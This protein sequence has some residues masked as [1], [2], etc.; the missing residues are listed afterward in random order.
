MSATSRLAAFVRIDGPVYEVDFAIRRF[1]RWSPDTMNGSIFATLRAVLGCGL[2]LT[3][4]GL[5][6]FASAAETE[7]KAGPP[8]AA[9]T[10]MPAPAQVTNFLGQ[11]C[12][13]CHGET[14]P[15]AGL[16]LTAFRDELSFLKARKKWDQ[17]IDLVH[18]GT[19]P[20]EDAPQPPLAEKEAFLKAVRTLFENADKNAKPDPGRVTV[21]RLNRAEYNNTIRDLLLVDLKP[22]EDFPS[23][24]VGHG[25][26]NIGDVLTLSPVLMERYLAAA[27]SIAERAVLVKLPPVPRRYLAARFL[28]PFPHN[29][30]EAEARFRPFRPADPNPI[31]AGP[32]TAGADYLKFTADADLML[33]ARLYAAKDA[34]LPVKVALFISGPNLADPSP[35]AEVDQLMGGNLKACKPMRILKVFEITSHDPQKIQEIEFPISKRGDIQKAGLAVVRP[36]EGEPAPTLFVENIW[37]EGPLEVRPL[38]HR[39][40]L[41]CDAAKPRAEQ[42]R[43]VIGR[44]VSRAFRRPATAAEVERYARIVDQAVA[45]GEPWEAGIQLAIQSVL[46]S[47]KF[48]FRFELDD[49]PEAPETRPIDEYQLAARL[50]YFLWSSLPDAEL[51]ELAA[52]GQL[53]ANLGSQVRRMLKDKKAN[54]LVENFALQW[55]QLG[56]LQAHAPDARLFPSFNEPLRAAMAEETRLFIAEIIREDRSL[57]DLI[58]A[59]FTY[60]N[61]PLAKHYGIAD[62]AGTAVGQKPAKPGAQPIRGPNFVRVSLA[63]PE[64][65]GLLQQAS[66]LTVTSNPTRT[67]PVKRGRWVLE[68]LL[69]APPPPPPP[70]VPE[71]DKPDGGPLVGT[72]RQR[73]E[74]HRR[75]PACANCHASMDPLGFAFENYDAIGAWRKADGDAP[76]DASGELPGGKSFQ[77]PAELKTIL[78]EKKSQFARCVVEKMLTYALGRGLEYYD[79]PTVDKI[80]AALERDGFKFST[81][82]AE[83]AASE[84]FRL[85]RGKE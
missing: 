25:F 84:P 10:S 15:K 57:L 27:E 69:G 34:K 70:N 45:A 61:E 20:P 43:E 28:H 17:L 5:G 77:G 79:K 23:D 37:S 49:R 60:L 78:L 30:P 74:Q 19:M 62:T 39:V 18:D 29:A 36:P 8:A 65:G 33:R 44:F 55:L 52:R 21:R 40:L 6:S 68:Q 53:T 56:R 7:A 38:S 1:A 9:P 2:G 42:T 4:A 51:T 13:R 58:Q 47:P 26:D 41:A 24:D 59:D 11:Y 46:V 75:N 50:S 3:F 85:R 72:L 12:T 80:S 83:I 54:S 66:V 22:A 35:D 32:L 64:R 48:L 14:N 16:S 81:L 76:I 31:F 63:A 67:S 82:A 71:L 73:M